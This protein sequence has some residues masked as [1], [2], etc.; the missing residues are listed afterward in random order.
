M[1]RRELGRDS[2]FFD[3]SAA[4]NEPPRLA[5][6][7]AP[8]FM[9][10]GPRPTGLG[11]EDT[12][13]RWSFDG[14]S[15]ADFTTG[16]LGRAVARSEACP[17]PEDHPKSF[18]EESARWIHQ[19]KAMALRAVLGEKAMA[20]R[21]KRKARDMAVRPSPKT[22]R[23]SNPV[24][25]VS[26]TLGASQKPT[27]KAECTHLANAVSNLPAK[28]KPANGPPSPCSCGTPDHSAAAPLDV[29]DR[30]GTLVMA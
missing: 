10:D 15:Q 19:A 8:A 17:L 16:S 28:R 6:S 21:G 27:S 4:H 24:T 9:Q 20:R 12:T 7:A 22:A 1:E 2:G 11:E 29:E 23:A 18:R 5:V 26:G 13:G 30:V 14:S 3:I 25:V